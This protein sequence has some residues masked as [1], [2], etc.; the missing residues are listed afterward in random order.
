MY[1]LT[2]KAKKNFLKE[3]TK[4]GIMTSKIFWL[5][6]KPLLTINGC[7]SDDSIGIENDGNLIYNEHELLELLKVGLSPSKKI[8]FHLLQ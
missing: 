4:D 2:K 1:S 3:A 8:S 5:T 6:V 7:I